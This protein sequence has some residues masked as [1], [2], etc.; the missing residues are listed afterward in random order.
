MVCW[1]E[2]PTLASLDPTMWC[3]ESHQDNMS[4][5]SPRGGWSLIQNVLHES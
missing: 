4:Q 3:D 2:L 5:S 1:D